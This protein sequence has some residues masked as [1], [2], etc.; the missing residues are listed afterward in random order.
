MC[1]ENGKF[2]TH[3]KG[4]KIALTPKKFGQILDIP[5]G[6]SMLYDPKDEK[7]KDYNKREFYFGL[8]RISEEEYHEKSIESHGREE[9]PKDFWSVGNFFINDRL[10][11]YFLVYV[12]IPRN[13]NH[14]NIIDVEMQVLYAVK[15]DITFITH[16]MEHF[17]VDFGDVEY[18]LMDTRIHKIPIKNV[19]QSIGYQYNSETK[20]IT[21]IGGN[22][23]GN[24]ENPQ[25]GDAGEDVPPPNV[26]SNQALF[27]FM[28][29][30]FSNLNTSINDQWTSAN[31]KIAQNHEAT[32]NRINLRQTDMNQHFSYLYSHLNIPP[33]DPNNPAAPAPLYTPIQHHFP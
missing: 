28:T 12:M 7:W 23:E 5:S 1:I 16:I 26:P 3:V 19:D 24:K 8:S 18:S 4:K 2:G 9:P 20:T 33:Y 14:C 11:H 32:T 10:L 6:G 17:N 27:E 31:N 15:N 21:F 22:N 29:T 25:E 30:Q 13:S